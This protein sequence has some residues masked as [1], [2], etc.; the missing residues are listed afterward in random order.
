VSLLREEAPWARGEDGAP[1]RAGVS[2]FGVSGT[3]AHVIL[4]EAPREGALGGGSVSSG[5]GVSV[6]NG[7]VSAGKASVSGSGVPVLG[8]G[9]VV[10]WVLSGRGAEGL[11]G[12][13]E[14]LVGFLAD[15]GEGAGV[16]DVGL[17]LA[18][19]PA[20]EDRAVVLGDGWD[21]LLAGL[22]GLAGGAPGVDLVRGVVPDG[23]VSGPVFVFAGQGSQ[24]AG[25]GVRL[26]E[27]SPVFAEWLGEC[28]RALSEFVDWSVLDV[29]RG[30]EGAPGLDRVDVVQPVLF[31]V[32]V[33]LAGLWRACGVEPVAVVGHSQGEIAA[34]CVAGGLSLADAARIIALRGRLLLELSGLGG[35]LSV[36]EGMDEVSARIERWGERVS[37]AAVNGAGSVVL[38]GEPGALREVLGE[39]E[40]DGVRARLIAVDY[41]AH[42]QPVEAVR[43][44]LLDGC[45]GI[46][47]RSGEVPF[48]SSVTGGELDTSLLDAEYWYRN[49]RET[50]R[51][52]HATRSLL[53][54][55][56]RVFI[57]TGP[58]PVLNL[59]IQETNEDTLAP[60]DA[61]QTFVCCSMRREQGGAER[62]VTALA[63][64]WV[65]GV[66]VDWRALLAAS[67]AERIALPR[68]A[69]QRERYW[70]APAQSTRNPLG[71]GIVSLAHPLL[72]SAVERAG[73]DGWILTGALSLQSHPWLADHAVAGTVLLPG[74]AFLELALYAGAHAGAA[75]VE[76]LVLE[77]ALPIDC[78]ALT[79]LQVS[80]GPAD[81]TGRRSVSIHSRRVDGDA[82]A[83]DGND[84]TLHASGVLACLGR[85]GEDDPAWEQA[86]ALGG[87]WPPVDAEPLDV[88]EFYER[89]LELGLEYGPAFQGLKAAWRY[90]GGVLAEVALPDDHAA[91]A[92]SF[93]VH[94]ALLD[95][96]LHAAGLTIPDGPG[97]TL[98][99]PEPGASDT[100]AVRLPFAW[101]G[102]RLGASASLRLRVGLLP[103]GE[104]AISLVAADDSGRS[105]AVVE[106]LLSRP[107]A[108][109]RLPG[110]RAGSSE[111]LLE[112]TWEP[113]SP[114]DAPASEPGEWVVLGSQ[115]S[116]LV[117]DLRAEGS[118]V[119]AYEDPDTLIAAV[120]SGRVLPEGVLLEAHA[121]AADGELEPLAMPERVSR[122][123]CEILPVLQRWLT[124]ERL[125]SCRLAVLTREAQPAGG[126]DALTGLAT[127]AAWGLLRSAQSEHP[128][129]FLV[130]DVGQRLREDGDDRQD[131]C[132]G[133]AFGSALLA[134]L[135]SGEPQIALREGE[136]LAP[137]LRRLPSADSLAI[138]LG[139]GDAWRLDSGR[140]GTLEDLSLVPC[141][142]ANRPLRPGEV[143]VATRAAG[144]NFRDVLLA[145]GMNVGDAAIGGEMAGVVLE[146]APGVG[147]L[148]PGDRVMGLCERGFSQ[149]SVAD[150]RL[151]VRIPD[152]WTFARAASIPIAYLT[153]YYGLVDLAATC[154]GERV[155]IHA[156]AGG[157]GMAAV[158]IARHLGAEVFATA[159]PAKW[160]AL[161]SLGLDDEHIA[162]SRTL[163]FAEDFLEQTGG[164]GVDVVLNSL[165][166]DFVDASLALLAR[167]G[168][169]LELGKTDVREPAGV[170]A[171]REDGSY[172][173]FSMEQA[174]PDRI[175]EIFS[176]LIGLFASG[177]LQPSPVA[178]WDIR[179]AGEA[180]RFMS[181]ARH[182]GKIVL[183]FPAGVGSDGTVLLTGGTGLLGGLLA[184]HLVVEHGVRSLL[185]ASR[186]G[187]AAVG[188]PALQEELE[189]LGA[190]VQV[191]ACDVSDR[192]AVVDLLGRA[193][194]EL[195][196]RGVVHAA[197][198]LD[199]GVIGSLTEERVERVLAPKVA[200]AWHLHELT[201]DL[202]LSLFAL[203]SS[204]A[205]TMGASGQ[206]NYAAANC[207]LDALAAHRRARGL[208]ASSI[209]WG[210]WEQASGLTGGL[211]DADT[212]R[213]ARQG[214]RPISS[215]EG[216][217]LF[218]L[219]VCSQAPAVVAVQLDMAA[220]RAQARMGLLPALMSDLV[221]ATRGDARASESL[222]GHLAAVPEAERE[223]VALELVRSQAAIVLGH[224]SSDAVDPQRAFKD[225][226][227]DSLASVELRNRLNAIAGVAL[228]ATVVFDH[229][230]ASILTERLLS[231]FAGV[232]QRRVTIPAANAPVA[233]DLIA[234]VGMSCRYPGGVRSP[235][236]LWQLVAEGGDAV[237]AFPNDRG[238]D[239]DGLFH[240]DPDR[241]G[242]SYVRHGGFI[243]DAAEFDA[244]F[245]D[246]GPREA[247]A[248][249]PQQRLLLEASWEVFEDA[250]IEPVSLRG[251]ATGVFSG[252][253]SI[254]YGAGAQL[255]PR[256][257]EGYL[258][259]GLLGS[260]ISGR[261]SYV[262][263]LEGPAVTVD[264]ACSSSL[265]A[266]HW[267]CRS[268]RCGECSLA[269]AAGVTVIATPRLFVEYS[270]QRALA[271][272]GRC[273]SFSDSADGAGFSEGVGVVLLERV[274][275]ALRNGHRIMAIVRGSATNQDGASNGLTAPNG[276][277]QE[278]VI[279]Q[280][281]AS[282]GLSASDVDAVEGHGTGTTLGDPI[283]AGA[284]LGA[285]GAER[286]DGRPL[287]LG[288]VK[289]NIG[290]TQ[291][292]AGV[293]GVIKMV[294][295]LEHGALPK[296]LHLSEPST[297]VDWS[298]GSVS[299]LTEVQPWERGERVRRAA[300]SSFGISGTNA[301]L[302]L[303][304]APV[305]IA[306]EEPVDSVAPAVGAGAAKVLL[307]PLSARGSGGLRR[308]AVRLGDDLRD[309]G[310]L[311]PADVGLSLSA[312]PALSDRAAVVGEDGEELRSGIEALAAGRQMAGVAVGVASSAR[313]VVFVF[314]GQGG[315]WE[316]MG[317]DLLRRSPVFAAEMRRCD[318]A[319]SE[320]VEWSV[321]DV[322]GG[323]SGAPD[324]AGLDVL[325]PAL[326]AVT[327]SLAALWRACGVEPSAVVGHS[328]GEV[329]AAYVAGGLSLR[330]AA[331]VSA[332]RGRMLASID[333]EGAVVSVAL[334]LEEARRRI[335]RWSPHLSIASV[336]GPSTVGVAGDE[337]ALEELLRTLEDD[338]VRARRVAG[339]PP[340]HCEKVERLRE[341]ALDLFSPVSP[342]S[343]DVPFYS[344]VTGGALET[345]GLD[346]G[347][348]YKNMRREVRFQDA[349]EALLRSGSRLF[350]EV[351]PHPVLAVPLQETLDACLGRDGDGR[352]VG[353]LRRQDG[354]LRRFMCS[355][356]ELWTAGA[357]V[358]WNAVFA[359][360]DAA[361]VK[362]P[363][364][365]F[366]RERF[367]L[368]SHGDGGD[369]RSVGVDR[370][371][372]PLLGAVL[373]RADGDG[374]LFTAHVSL[375]RQPW[376]ADHSVLGTTLFPGTAFVELALHAG[377]R[378][379]C[380]VVHELVLEEPLALSGDASVRLQMAVGG[381]DE[382]GRCEFAVFS[383]MEHEET[384]T[385]GE[386]WTRNASGTLSGDGVAPVGDPSSEA[387]ARALGGGAAGADLNMPA[388]SW[389]PEGAVAVDIEDAYAS[390]ADLGLEYGPAFTGL[391]ALW[392]TSDAL[393]CE[394]SLPES[395]AENARSYE[396][397]PALLDASLHAA[398]FVD[399][400]VHTGEDELG[401]SGLSLPFSWHD[402]R[403]SQRGASELR[404]CLS[405][406]SSSN[407]QGHP[408]PYLAASDPSG[409]PVA[410]IGS[411]V[412]R[413]V[414]ADALKVLDGARRSLFRL[415]WEELSGGSGDRTGEQWTILGDEDSPLAIE[416]REGGVEPIAFRDVRTLIDAH[417]AEGGL[418]VG[419]VLLDARE[420]PPLASES[421]HDALTPAVC[422]ALGRLQEWL[423]EQA[424]AECRLVVL[425]S[426]AQP[427]LASDDVRG[428]ASAGVWGLIRSAQAEDPGRLA[429]LDI[430]GATS[431][432]A[433]LRATIGS[434]ETQL[435]VRD[436]VPYAPR[437]DRISRRL[438]NS[439]RAVSDDRLEVA[440]GTVLI[441]G[442]TGGLG[443]L[444]ARHMVSGL[445]VRSLLLASRKGPDA[446]G[447]E[448]LR[449]ELEALGAHVEIV[450]CDVAERSQVSALLERVPAEYPL[451]GVV[452]G[453]V[454]LEDG[455]I[456][457]LT[458]GGVERVMAPK[459]LA[460]WHL[461]ELTAGM[462]LSI[463]V[464][465]SSAVGVLGAPGQ[466]NYAAANAFLDALAAYRRAKGLPA[467]SIAWGLWDDPSGSTAG[468]N[469]IDRA[470]I[471]RVG[472]E[473]LSSSEGLDLFDAALDS[474]EAAVIAANLDVQALRAQA[475]AGL[476]PSFLCAGTAPRRTDDAAGQSWRNR[477]FGAS[478]PERE[479]IALELVQSEAAI[480]LGHS[481]AAA[482]ESDRAFKELGFDSLAAVELRNRLNEATGLHIAATS[483][484]EHPNPVALAEHLIEEIA[485]ERPS[486]ASVVEQELAKLQAA[487]ADCGAEDTVRGVVADRLRRL[488]VDLEQEPESGE[489]AAV[490][491]RI[492]IASDEEIFA[493]LDSEATSS[494]PSQAD[495]TESD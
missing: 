455:V 450:A 91:A 308:Q 215:E 141:K 112:V 372:H 493:L 404:V 169:F 366:A 222:S 307:W 95:A 460:A 478:A 377:R 312:R 232:E 200:G 488:L 282:A 370:S 125:A 88:G 293:A 285:Y 354:D 474:G 249:D 364:Y 110:A 410:S 435:A 203:F 396:L 42:S 452:H 164:A 276:P 114:A 161:T 339:T 358:D 136:L 81:E 420:D 295:A 400:I 121:G 93:A 255:A 142:D 304:E 74:T 346:A 441:T 254:D 349:A 425:T 348:W 157:V 179:R 423:P 284:L 408:V 280:A 14:R 206:A 11:R 341:E 347:Y 223:G 131:D 375:D 242:A 309:R 448:D 483:A 264:T 229:P 67:G 230:N 214:V 328:Q 383:R 55:G 301:H 331:R 434:G 97:V 330:D 265:V 464:L 281:L 153:A 381:V 69:F 197:G 260:V 426:N 44:Q 437:L 380:E 402:V 274:S 325:Q 387:S 250:G 413:R 350:L 71:G 204:G 351:G 190:T 479:R 25:M 272:D 345:A 270:R 221:P 58:H 154:P 376:L 201:R 145:L 73:E 298:T 168:R 468:L 196:L 444:L 373:T 262:F 146:V 117:G 394:V 175:A 167:D 476:A 443:A 313:R 219:A 77:A 109:D 80:L 48:Y 60:S 52:D 379:G 165:S 106:S 170:L 104:G 124:E 306:S 156:A 338:G 323:V 463:F 143:R 398:A 415:R 487:I 3:N 311:D 353:S 46:E 32:M 12:Q 329:A 490:L 5:D 386:R 491:E 369:V 257:V 322:L 207:F 178:S 115:E 368:T 389:P 486:G 140:A 18:C 445:G 392:R 355:L 49:L 451:C 172:R 384:A 65:H 62:F 454:V 442:G 33:A 107:V 326:F 447:A 424:L 64:A 289:S 449:R 183:A 256:E 92:H 489:R 231:E 235:Q 8:V 482:V 2:S 205:A 406:R 59:A 300:V 422:G 266:I 421:Q 344:T 414:S 75:E 194:P 233:E 359:G 99:D 199:D 405:R 388:A 47:P 456:G 83:T 176:E 371:D 279:R 85:A 209:A 391:T 362:L 26:L 495:P 216:L 397:H 466:G 10:P 343:G 273:K 310:D 181:K 246:I 275:D 208:A 403:L 192:D 111:S 238:W 180:F 438:G 365:A 243:H 22:D 29:L 163:R 291:A 271:P 432:L 98:T 84:W 133:G 240:P 492:D 54:A 352:V 127:S 41:A 147:D 225:L 327:I 24:W 76:E 237:S 287:W 333:H 367:W 7:S 126:G 228:P 299:L 158:Q 38:S 481:S 9:G 152:G 27:E 213:M 96:A 13:A 191:I 128:G 210:L 122:A 461:H 446:E 132:P 119:L 113:I 469:A 220:L 418:P 278:R 31:C 15:G 134:A 288:S 416:L 193:P 21:G 439:S 382:A 440:T 212:A 336:N 189:S 459:A 363:T 453:A 357:E 342:R 251:S 305:A 436:G 123:V 160:P 195:P 263:G 217:R 53:D 159:S 150:R 244:A 297:G 56:H 1:R 28:D 236:E 337:E 86:A 315:Q 68:Y 90:Q 118:K 431:P 102:V 226:G 224:A 268:L 283:E 428:L 82:K 234:I 419:T 277:S 248:M 302:I 407:G 412:A 457:S 166:G 186:A 130:I 259:K 320:Y 198:A 34:A 50:V 72:D 162:S 70:L 148:V 87:A 258:G 484:F 430:D 218:D 66:P 35:M 202:D 292:A 16:G 361:G 335:S 317:R 245:F 334:G 149:I 23:G 108:P 480:V 475:R 417:V 239:V 473:G 253:S 399:G 458:D 485:R 316:G 138:P 37:L 472:I 427:V 267:A 6:G 385:E 100:N 151:L 477:L 294:K 465:Y 135:G 61:S 374:W 40:A 101:T 182:V 185:L 296:T 393:F 116:R 30:E 63:E 43:E 433:S 429:L 356:G 411:L 174:G 471:S 290:H 19:K 155:L 17:S 137:R 187:I 45:E 103:L 79:Q 211:A 401:D 319:L 252:V 173:A 171:G 303:E 105:V 39:C 318:E 324:G 360:S 20:F 467:V 36:S 261:V 227:F 390:F 314:S 129:R 57:E 94:P 332:L 462:D 378:V 340:S 494:S 470:R 89:L 247:L 188:A 184:R 51:F 269:L 286:S 144:L 321:L 177:E 120:V 395:A 409:R 78:D 4:E 139:V 241:P